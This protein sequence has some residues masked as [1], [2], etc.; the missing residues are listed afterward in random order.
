MRDGLIALVASLAFVACAHSHRDVLHERGRIQVHGDL[1]HPM[2]LDAKAIEQRFGGKVRIVDHRLRAVPIRSVVDACL[3]AFG[4]KHKN[5]ELA[6]VVLLRCSDGYA[7]AYTYEEIAP[8]EQEPDLYLAF[9]EEDGPLPEALA[10]A[11]VVR[12]GGQD[13]SRTLRGV[14]EIE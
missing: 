10:P 11:R 6:F 14:V 8:Y 1:A 7:V 9:A 13:D 12:I 2:V 5:P 4:T 3:P